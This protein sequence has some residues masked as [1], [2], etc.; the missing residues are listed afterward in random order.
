MMHVN[1]PVEQYAEA[2][3]SAL[4]KDLPPILAKWQD[5]E[6]N[7]RPSTRDVKVVS[8]PQ[9]WGSTALGFGGMGGAAMTEAIV[10]I[11]SRPNVSCVYFGGRLA[12]TI[13][14]PNEKFWLDVSKHRMAGVS[15]SN[16]YQSL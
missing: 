15:Q 3:Y 14:D 8:F 16:I 4:H 9:V 12:Y 1:N 13:T 11:V 7:H 5:K 2:L 10:V 6:Y